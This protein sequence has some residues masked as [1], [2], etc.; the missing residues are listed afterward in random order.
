MTLTLVYA[1]MTQDRRWELEENLSRVLPYVDTAVVVDNGSTDGSQEWLRSQNRVVLVERQWD[2]SFVEGRNA[3]LRA[4]DRIAANASDPVVLCVADT[5]EFYSDALIRDLR[6]IA[7]WLYLEDANVLRIRCRSVETDWKGEEYWSQLDAWHKPLIVV[8]E[9]G[10][11]YRGI[12]R[13]EVHEDLLIPSGRRERTLADDGGRY[14]YVHRK[15]HG[16]IWL[17]GVRNFFAGGGGPNLGDLNPLWQ[18]FRALWER[19]GVHTSDRMVD[20]L[21]RGEIDPEIA[22]WFIRHR[23]LGTPWDPTPPL[24]PG[25]PDGCSEVREGF[26]AYFVLLHPDEMPLDLPDADAAY[27]DYRHEARVIWGPRAPTWALV[28]HQKVAL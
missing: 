23:L 15:R 28:G 3:Y 19:R 1:M 27:M 14:V 22:E 26:L 16:E 13:T 5:D 20:A 8:W 17:R 24:W 12:G 4:V 11:R 9:P 2:D 21:R 7:E 25:W 6:G 10:M 18:P